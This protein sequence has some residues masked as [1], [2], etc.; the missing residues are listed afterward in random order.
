MSAP[1][2]LTTAHMPAFT[3]LS[4]ATGRDYVDATI[5]RVSDGVALGVARL[6]TMDL[7]RQ[8]LP[9]WGGMSRASNRLFVDDK[10]AEHVFIDH[11]DEMAA[12]GT[13]AEEIEDAIE[14][15]VRAESGARS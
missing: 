13:V 8:F 14:R 4:L 15:M 6:A 9:D 7:G 3:A 1:A 11:A 12:D 5:V 2:D 10:L